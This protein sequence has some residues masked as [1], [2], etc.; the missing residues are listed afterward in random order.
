[1][2]AMKKRTAVAVTM[3]VWVAALGSAAALAYELNRPVHWAEA[4][5]KV[6]APIGNAAYAG[7]QPVAELSPVIYVPAV[8][9]VGTVHRPALAPGP[10]PVD[11]SKMHCAAWRELDMGSGRV[12]VCD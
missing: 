2:V 11:I 6:A 3:G 12:Q 10:K 7:A 5:S 9:V 4:I 8:T 1:M